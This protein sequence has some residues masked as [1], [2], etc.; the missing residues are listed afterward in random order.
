MHWF[1]DSKKLIRICNNE[2]IYV[3]VG[4]SVINDIKVQHVALEIDPSLLL[5]ETDAP[6]PIDGVPNHPG[7][8]KQVAES[9]ARLNGSELQDIAEQTSK[10][11]FSIYEYR[12]NLTTYSPPYIVIRSQNLFIECSF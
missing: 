5:L 1:T 9:I 4:P 6:V 11:F 2:G 10:K 8:V 12:P 7:R 3:S